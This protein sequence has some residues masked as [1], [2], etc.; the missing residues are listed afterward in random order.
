MLLI[1]LPAQWTF[2]A[3]EQSFLIVNNLRSLLENSNFKESVIFG[4]VLKPRTIFSYLFPFFS[5]ERVSVQAGVVFSYKAIESLSR[6]RGHFFPRSTETALFL[7]S[8]EHDVRIISPVDEDGMHLFHG[9]DL[10]TLIP[11]AYRNKNGVKIKV[12]SQL[13]ACCCSDHSVAFGQMT[14]KDIRLAH[15]ASSTWRVFGQAG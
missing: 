4:R 10:K 6:C 8:K 13:T 1:M 5:Y 3:D 14:Y 12:T 15:F 11:S 9:N 7:C 2:I